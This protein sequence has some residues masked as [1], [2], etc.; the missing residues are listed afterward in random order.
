[1]HHP[2]PVSL[3]LLA[4]SLP[5]AQ[6]ASPPALATL[7]GHRLLA[8][9][10]PADGDLNPYAVVVA[11]VSA[12]TVKAGDVLVDNFNARNNFQGTG[13]TIMDY[14][15]ATKAAR[16]FA[17][18]PRALAGC[19]G[20]VGLTAAMTMLKA[21][22]IIVGSAPSTD[23]TT[24]TRG[25]GCLIVLDPHGKLAGTIAGPEIDDPWG[26]VAVIDRGG[27]ATLFVSNVG[28]GI[29]ADIGPPGQPPVRR[30]N[31]L[32][33]D[34]MLP[35][36]KPPVVEGKT[37]IAD[38]FPAEADAGAFLIG[39]T[40]LA[41]APDGTLYVSD[42]LG[43][44]VVAIDH[45][46][47]RADSAGT[48]RVVSEGGLLKRPLAMVI[49]P[50]GD[51]LVTNALNGQLVEID[52]TTGTQRGALWLDSDEAQDPPGNGDLFGL[53]MTP[54]GKGLYYVEDDTNALMQA[55]R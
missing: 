5:L 9:T 45:A 41:L 15:P 16:L 28:F 1:M 12:G 3:L 8:S 18:L 33:I 40:G 53:A 54:D 11:P 51:L 55:P 44:R 49:A 21:G 29:G 38:G 20:G 42:A 46:A 2:L 32:R 47:T 22:W 27:S 39:P 26:N 48:G 37:V 43:N 7:H 31:V 34:L 25:A 23:G 4:A 52:P 13:T 24:K 36:G 10:V 17:A 14:D 35:A 6:A 50:N 19:P 30:A